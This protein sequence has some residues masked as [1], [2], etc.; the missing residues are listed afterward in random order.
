MCILAWNREPK[1]EIPAKMQGDSGGRNM[2]DPGG[3]IAVGPPPLMQYAADCALDVIDFMAA[4]VRGVDLIDVTPTMREAWRTH[5]AAYYPMLAP[6]NRYWFASAPFT[7]LNIQTT[8]QQLPELS[9]EMCRAVVGPHGADDA[10]VHRSGAPRVTSGSGP[11]VRRP[12]GEVCRRRTAAAA[13]KSRDGGSRSPGAAGAV[14]PPRKL[15]N[16]AAVL[17]NRGDDDDR[18]DTRHERPPAL[19]L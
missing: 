5:L 7:L 9:R 2:T 6:V 18:L 13:F 16:T 1:T 3:L 4:V 14:Q 10:A 11:A 17:G 15:E 8:W 12:T 19:R